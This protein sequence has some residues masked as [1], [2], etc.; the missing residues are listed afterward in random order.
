VTMMSSHPG[1]GAAK[2]TWLWSDVEV[3][4]CW[5]QYYRVILAMA[6]LGRLGRGVM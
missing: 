4:S 6:L 5:R 2:A 3:E 1:D